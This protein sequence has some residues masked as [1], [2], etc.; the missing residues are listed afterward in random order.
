MI[1]PKRQKAT[2]MRYGYFDD[3]A[4]EYVIDRPDT[5]APWVN[6]LGSPAYGAIISNNAGGYSFERSGANGRILRYVFNQFDQPGRY[7]YLRDDESG[8]FWSAS[9]QPVAKDLNDYQVKCCHGMGYTRMEASYAGISSKAVYYVPQGKAYE[10]WALTVTND[11]DRDRSLTLTGYAEFTNHSNYEQDQVNLQYSLFIGRTVFEGN[12]ITQQIHGNLDA[13][14]QGEDVDDKTVTERFFGLAGAPVSSYCGDKTAFLGAYHGYG[15]PQGVAAGDLGNLES[16]NEN[17]CGALSCK[18]KLA[19]GESK[20]IL[21]ATGMKPSAQAAAILAGYTDPAAQVQQEVD[22]LKAEWYSRFSHLQVET[23]DPAFNTMLN[24]WNAYNCFIT[25]IWSRAASLIYCG[26]RNGYGY[27]DTVQDI[28]GIIHLEPEMACEKIRFMLSAQVDNGG[29]LP[30]V[31]FTHNPGHE[32]TPD[33]PSYVK[34]TG[35]PAYRADDALWLFPTVYKY[36]AESGNLAFLDEVI[37]FAN[38]DQGTVYEHLKRAV[39]FSLNHLGPHG[40]PAG[41]YADWNDCL[42][43]GANGESAFVAFQFY[44][45]MRILRQ[46][47]AHRGADQDV[48]WLDEKLTEYQSRIQELCW[49]G[50]RFI[51]GFTE[52]G[53]RIGEAAAPEANFWLNPQSWAVISGLADSHQADT[54]MEGVSQRLNTAYGAVLMDPPYH[55]HAFDG[56]LAV[57]YNPGTK[58]NAGIFSQSQGWLILAEA[59]CGHGERAFGYFTENA[60][61]AQNDRAEIRHLEPYC[62]E[63]FTEG[64]AS[65]HFGRSQV[66][67]LTGTA[68][69]VMVGCVE[70]I[71]GLRPDLDGLRLAPAI[72]KEWDSF[73]MEKDFRGHRLHICVENPGHH[74]SGCRSLTLNGQAMPDNYIPASALR[75]ENDIILTM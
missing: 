51:R 69:T 63:Q 40:L 29:G 46:F 60:P 15:N 17:S 67:W 71:L 30:L 73:T 52:A 72:P 10:V 61:A 43:L 47:A 65:K 11:S 9:W 42:R 49:D 38:K 6:Y 34:E 1:T 54:I 74:E 39:E 13:L 59:L 25:F 41:L 28:Q 36:V 4:R 27:R 21:F 48:R 8:D 5:P 14:A 31:K 68:S 19:P 66:H 18:V 23:P 37:P 22:A 3:K 56:A 45:A 7:I 16:Y 20:T 44:Y 55:A 26:L 75:D 58:E 62:Y 35:H 24:T 12:R 32:D 33:D 64:P 57:I 53:E 70:G 50:D 2:S